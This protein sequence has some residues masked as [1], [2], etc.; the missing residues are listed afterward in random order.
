MAYII[1]GVFGEAGLYQF[2]SHPW[3]GFMDLK[4]IPH[5]LNYLF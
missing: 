3:T 4:A 2:G 5:K 1:F